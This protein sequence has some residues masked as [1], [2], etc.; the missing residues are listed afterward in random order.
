MTSKTNKNLIKILKQQLTNCSAQVS[1]AGA[2][3]LQNQQKFFVFTYFTATIK[4][5]YLTDITIVNEQTNWVTKSINILYSNCI[6][7]DCIV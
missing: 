3:P 4:M 5:I 7:S 1:V 6:I 2:Q